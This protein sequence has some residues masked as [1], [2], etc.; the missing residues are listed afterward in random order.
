MVGRGL[1]NRQ[2]ARE[3]QV[4]EQTVENNLTQVFAKTGCRSRLDL[5]L[6]VMEGRPAV[7]LPSSTSVPLRGVHRTGH[8]GALPCSGDVRLSAQPVVPLSH[9]GA[10]R[11]QKGRP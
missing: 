10:P 5:A 3:L 4:S 9:L 2:I 11:P 7:V 6:A 8:R 1:T